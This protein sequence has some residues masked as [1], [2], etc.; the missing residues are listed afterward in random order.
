MFANEQCLLCL[1][2]RMIKKSADIPDE[3]RRI[4]YVTKALRIAAD[5]AGAEP[6]PCISHRFDEL[7]PEYFGTGDLFSGVKE[8]YNRL[9]L[10]MSDDIRRRIDASSD[11]L[12]TAVLLAR[13]GNYIDFGAHN[14]VN[15]E[16]LWK[17]LERAE[18]EQLDDSL[19]SLLRK[20]L[21]Y[22]NRLVYLADNCGE[23]V[24][25]KLLIERI[26]KDFP[27]IRVKVLVKGIPTLNDATAEDA[28]AIGLDSV[29]EV[30]STGSGIPGTWRPD[31]NAEARAALD[32]A[33]VIISKGQANYETM[34]G[35]GLNVYYLLLCKCERFEQR[36]SVPRYTGLFVHERMK[37]D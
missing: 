37:F 21:A 17:T 29:A 34:S 35:C 36:F 9:L 22:T 25:D 19:F 18:N 12:R 33:D 23:I 11:P 32:D 3:K 10:D 28:L 24:L 15:D 26:K 5:Y 4:E 13:A 27:Q 14:E 7:A 31:I 8:K 6:A 1:I 2:D 16:T 30:V 20:S